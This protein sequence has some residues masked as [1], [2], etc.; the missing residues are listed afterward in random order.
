M[1]AARPLW[2]LFLLVVA[3]LLLVWVAG[4]VVA[5]PVNRPVSP[6]PP[7]GTVVHME[8][9]DGVPIEGSY[10]AGAGRHAPAVLLL[11]GINTNRNQFTR[12]AEW[13]SGLGYAV[14]AID[15]R[16]HGGS[17]AV[18][19]TFGLHEA[20]DA[21]AGF[22]FLKAQ[23]PGRRI[24]VIGVSL[25]GAAALLGEAGPLPADAMVLHGVYPDI[26]KAIVNRLERSGSS[27]L[28]SLSEPL[29]SYQSYAR[30]GV[31]P[32]RIAP[33]DRIRRYR[34]ALLVVGGTDDDATRV[35][36]SRALYQAAAG[37]KSLWLVEG[38]DHVET[39]KLF[40]RAYRERVRSLF[41]RTLGEPR[42]H[43]P[44]RQPFGG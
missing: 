21:A 28:A 14:L 24:G 41:A 15:L 35:E 42:G 13:L 7:P 23:A 5:R 37:A 40:D 6:P 43:L 9:A 39:S 38:A 18:E 32:E 34:G 44:R 19:R 22:A 17:G 2:T 20:R 26:R 11:H 36:D 10:W 31:A 25:G 30:Y 4:S 3:G 8:A 1:K 29:L 12:H 16:G 27:S 33:I